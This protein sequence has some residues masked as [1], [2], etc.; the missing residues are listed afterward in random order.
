MWLDILV[1]AIMVFSIARGFHNGFVYTAL[2]TI[3]WLVSIVAAIMIYPF[4]AS[5]LSSRT[6]LYG[7]LQSGAA[8]RLQDYLST[9]ANEFLDG[10]PNAIAGAVE[11]AVSALSG[12]LA[13]GV[14][15]VCFGVALFLL[16][17]FAIRLLFILI[18]RL[19]SKRVRRGVI[20]AADGLLGL[21]IG[22]VKGMFLIFV[23][24][25][26]ILPLS[27]FIS[28]G[29]NAFVSDAL[30]S[31]MFARDLYNNNLLLLILNSFLTF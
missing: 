26:L 2:H 24:L 20:G 25:A 28:E 5:F 3:S 7:A 8:R 21:A 10:V 31:S 4:A 18:L 13:D 9:Q 15:S 30:F 1:I 19:F 17:S 23:V 11:E 14:A 16:L 29:A 12:S 6:G 22:A 27:M